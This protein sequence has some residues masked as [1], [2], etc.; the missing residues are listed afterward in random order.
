M[1]KLQWLIQNEDE[2]DDVA[3]A[4]VGF[5]GQHDYSL[6][7]S[8][9]SQIS[10][11]DVRVSSTR[12]GPD[13]IVFVDPTC[14]VKSVLGNERSPCQRAGCNLDFDHST[15]DVNSCVYHV[16]ELREGIWSCCNAS[17]ANAPGCKTGPHSGKE[18]AAVVRVESLPKTVEGIHLVSHFE[19]NIYPGVPHTLGKHIGENNTNTWHQVNLTTK[20]LTTS[21][22]P[23]SINNHSGS[24]LQEY[25]ATVHG[26]FLR[27]RERRRRPRSCVDL[28]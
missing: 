7:G 14:V 5:Y 12:P 6:D 9:V 13:S 8:V 21:L 25:F 22:T 23:V 1:S 17:N 2:I 11:E 26:L 16:G 24:D 27:G 18:R 4:F 15:N 19:V 10:L 20:S 28:S 3:I